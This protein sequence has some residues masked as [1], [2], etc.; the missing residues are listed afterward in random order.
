MKKFI[1][2]TVLTIFVLFTLL[3]S[4]GQ[5]TED[6]DK[7][8]DEEVINYELPDKVSAGHAKNVVMYVG[9]AFQNIGTDLKDNNVKKYK[10]AS[11][12][13]TLKGNTSGEVI[14]TIE[15]SLVSNEL[16]GKVTC[17]FK[18][19]K[20][21]G[22][23]A[24]GKAVV[25]GVL[26]KDMVMKSFPDLSNDLVITTTDLTLNGTNISIS[27]LSDTFSNNF[28]TNLKSAAIKNLTFWKD[29]NSKELFESIY[30]IVGTYATGIET[31]ATIS[32]TISDTSGTGQAK[33]DLYLKKIN[34]NF[35]GTNAKITFTNYGDK[36][37]VDDKSGS[38]D[39][40]GEFTILVEEA[41][42]S[43]FEDFADLLKQSYVP[44]PVESKDD[45]DSKISRT[46][47][48]NVTFNAKVTLNGNLTCS[49]QGVQV[50]DVSLYDFDYGLINSTK[51]FTLN[52]T[53]PNSTLNQLFFYDILSYGLSVKG[54][55]VINGVGYNRDDFVNLI[56]L[57]GIVFDQ[58]KKNDANKFL[59][60]DS[61]EYKDFKIGFKSSIISTILST[62]NSQYQS[63]KTKMTYSL[64]GINGGT[65]TLNM[66]NFTLTFDNFSNNDV[67]FNGTAK[68]KVDYLYDWS[69]VS[70]AETI[71]ENGISIS[72]YIS[73]KYVVT[74]SCN[75]NDYIYYH[76]ISSDTEYN[77]I[78]NLITNTSDKDFVKQFVVK[79]DYN[80]RYVIKQTLS[81]D[82]NDKLLNIFKSV[83]FYP[84]SNYND[85]HK[86]KITAN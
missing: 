51:Q 59:T 7:K 83:G 61:Q 16:T 11:G 19:Y 69:G 77:K 56:V 26:T 24:S 35:N 60:L 13:W 3:V 58:W 25:S 64:N 6:K 39:L 37:T 65:A 68:V 82:E 49:M 18:N 53:N 10:S 23:D 75:L 36:F 81:Q 72:G 74:Y 29:G 66:S 48:T 44:V 5:V 50:G 21:P 52:S 34:N 78:L 17:D 40:N 30:T 22:I 33:V 2:L 31:D 67:K 28:L 20:S 4:C 54:A 46:T 85:N 47:G 86:T 70:I 63:N 41:T 57:D 76:I 79:D 42:I 9:N 71:G 84:F 62:L 15:S 45:Q 55:I 8:E 12:V 14:I 38:I 43:S 32:A 73:G 80:D 1:L 27:K